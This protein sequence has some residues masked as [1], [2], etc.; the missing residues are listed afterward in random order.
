VIPDHTALSLE[1]VEAILWDDAQQAEVDRHNRRAEE[2][3]AEE[4]EMLFMETL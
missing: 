4:D 1:E 3:R 2:L